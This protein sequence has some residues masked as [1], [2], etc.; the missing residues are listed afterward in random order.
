MAHIDDMLEEIAQRVHP[1]KTPLIALHE[2]ET[3]ATATE[4]VVLL[5]LVACM[6]IAVVAAF[7]EQLYRLYQQAV[8]ALYFM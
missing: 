8:D 5:V 2:D 3:G 6:I 4:Y 1:L 7:G